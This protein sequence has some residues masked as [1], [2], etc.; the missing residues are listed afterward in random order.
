MCYQI[1]VNSKGAFMRSLHASIGPIGSNG[2]RALSWNKVS[3][4][5]GVFSTKIIRYE[6]NKQLFV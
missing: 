4:I 1:P 5:N 2:L 3:T 6:E